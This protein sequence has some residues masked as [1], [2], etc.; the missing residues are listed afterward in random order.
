MR[1]SHTCFR[2]SS[3]AFRTNSPARATLGTASRWRLQLVFN[4]LALVFAGLTLPITA[5]PAHAVS[6]PAGFVVE[7]AFPG[8]A[9]SAPVQV[10]FLPDGKKFV[11]EQGGVVW[12]ILEDGTQVGTPFIDLSQRVLGDLGRGLLGVAIDPNYATNPWVYLCY[13]ADPDSNGVDEELRAWSRL[14]RYQPDSGNPLVADL[15]TRE[16]LIG[17]TWSTGVPVLDSFHVTGM[18]RF[19]ADGTLLIA[20]GDAAHF[21]LV[22]PGGFDAAGFLPGRADPAEDL[23]AFRSQTLNSMCGKIL[24]VDPATGLGVSSNPYWDGNGASDR[25]RVWLY[26]IRNAFRFG[27]RPGTGS[28]NPADGDPGTLY[29]GDVGWNTW[30]ALKVAATGGLNL[31]WP[32]EEGPFSQPDY[33]AVDS[34][35]AG[36]TNVLCDAQPSAENP[37]AGTFTPP[38]LW[39]VHPVPSGP[40]TPDDSNPVGW[41]GNSVTG[42]VFYEGT[43]YPAPYAGSYFIGDF[44]TNWIRAVQ[45]DA[46]D[47]VVGI[48]DFITAADGPVDIEV[49]PISGDLYYVALH[50]NE[51][52]RIRFTPTKLIELRADTADGIGAPAVPG[53]ASPWVDLADA[54]DGTLNNFAGDT[55]SGWQGDGTNAAPYRLQFDGTDDVVTIPAGS[56]PELQT[57]SSTSMSMWFETASDVSTDQYLFE[58]LETFGSPF[59]G[60][61]TAVSGGQL[62][63]WLDPWIDIMPATPNTWYHMVVAKEAGEVRVYV[64]GDV[65]YTAANANLG[66]QVSEIVVGASTLAGAG[67]Y[68]NYFLGSIAQVCVFDGALDDAAALAEYQA[69][70]ALYIPPVPT[71][72]VQFRADMAD[73]L[74]PYPIPGTDS[75][76]VDLVDSHVATLANFGD[77][78]T[79]SRNLGASKD[80]TLYEHAT[81]DL[82][83]GGGR[84]FFVGKT[85]SRENFVLRRGLLAFDIAGG[86]PPGTSI[87]KVTLTL[88]MSRTQAGPQNVELHRVTSDWG[89]G[90]TVAGGQEGGGALA[91]NGDATWKHTFYDTNFWTSPGGD[92]DATVS[93][94]QSVDGLGSYTWG[95]TAQMVSDVQSWLDNPATNYGWLLLL[96]DEMTD[97]T[98]KRFGTR[99]ATDAANR[100]Q[101]AVEYTVPAMAA[102]GWRGDGSVAEPYRLLFDGAN[103]IVTIPGTSIP[104]LNPASSYSMSMWFHTGSD[105]TT[106]QYLVEWVETF[107]SPWA[108]MT[109]GYQN[110][111]LQVYMGVAGWGD[112]AAVSTDTWYHVVVAKRPG[113]V[114]VFL[115]GTSAFSAATPNIGSQVSEVVI[116]AG[117]FG[118]VASYD[119]YHEGSIAQ[120]CIY[121]GAVNAAGALAEYQADEALYRCPPATGIVDLVA[122]QQ[123]TGNPVGQLTNINL[124]WSA[125]AP[126]SSVDIY[127]KA[128]G[129]YPEYDDAPNAGSVPTPPANPGDAGA[130]GWT[131]VGTSTGT[132]LSDLPPSRD[133][134]YYVGFVTNDCRS[135]SGVS[136][137]TAGALN[138]QLGDISDGLTPGTGDNLV[139]TEDVDDLSAHYGAAVPDLL[140]EPVL[141]FGPTHDASVLGRPTTDNATDFEELILLSIN[142][143]VVSTGIAKALPSPPPPAPENSLAL[144][145][146]A[147]PA[148]GQSFDVRLWMTGDGTIQGLSV[149]LEWNPAVVQPVGFQ[150]GDLLAAQG[151]DAILLSP[152]AGVVDAALLG[153]R[154]PGI[155]GAGL[156]ASVTFQVID[157]GAADI[158]AGVL[159]VRDKENMHVVMGIVTATPDVSTPKLTALHPPAP[160]P[161]NPRT[162]IS[163]DISTPGPVRLTIYAINGRRVK[164]LVNRHLAAGAYSE[165]W[166]GTDDAGRRGASGTYIARLVAPDKTVTRRMSL[167]K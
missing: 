139:S 1:L 61:T 69:D 154:D 31:G 112:I 30:E 73:G 125:L 41:V 95:S 144:Q 127:R 77:G 54:H 162:R 91:A 124:S 26:G 82:S 36:N 29:L 8:A 56:V 158:Q 129:N 10:V 14:E 6:A 111:T 99:E 107:T 137:M 161:F 71:K 2:L 103:D 126:G 114:E 76:W 83:N 115:D 45:V 85:A 163:F 7:N 9:F 34:T 28:S 11:V 147:L 37:L 84:Y 142:Y 20:S 80:N 81:D 74:S 155:S 50:A 86:I 143:E 152:Q 89:E 135:V 149:P 27:I 130:E 67:S 87:T 105:V 58:W 164:T 148:T 59:A 51:V 22:D 40:Y 122:D 134:W 52:R 68:G 145:I 153:P 43:T 75:P 119:R 15:S 151:G 42:G 138:Y 64:D 49:D 128:F 96:A 157:Q 97:T 104:E 140:F 25:S 65:K 5:P 108:G 165:I 123:R 78:T 141:D 94:V 90:T 98:A 63:V 109:L 47:N 32:C 146:P 39:W 48:S 46:N 12:I 72:L 17:G 132:S 44:A 38:T 160:N 21:S 118:G 167:L 159:R 93:G 23:G 55:S 133:F 110:G 33:A 136:N 35:A 16:I 88:D 79:E 156:L 24:R 4:L 131:H 101:L 60:I 57:V 62:R 92:F 166:D 100:P 70:Q 102:S 113:L 116:G 18:I 120:F 3:F 53:A 117:T 121:E 13:T 66:D 106:H 19:A 150:A